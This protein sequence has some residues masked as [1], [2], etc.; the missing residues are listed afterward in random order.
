MKTNVQ[1][2]PVDTNC[3]HQIDPYSPLEL[4]KNDRIREVILQVI[5]EYVVDFRRHDAIEMYLNAFNPKNKDDWHD[6]PFDGKNGLDKALVLL[7]ITP[8]Q[9][10]N[11]YESLDK[12]AWDIIEYSKNNADLVA[13]TVLSRWI[14]EITN[15]FNS[16]N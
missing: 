16:K 10:F 1:K 13:L 3:E 4:L 8:K 15:Y 7:G 9:H 2:N 12:M 5:S 14:P 11:F 6:H